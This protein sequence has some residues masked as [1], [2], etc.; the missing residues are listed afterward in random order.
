M[1]I[2]ATEPEYQKGKSVFANVAEFQFVPVASDEESIAAFVQQHTCR[3]V[4]LGVERYVGPLYEAIPKGG[5]IVRFGV[6]TDSIDPLQTKRRGILVA[7]TPGALDRS[8][9]EHTI[10][11]IGALVRH[12]GQGNQ[13]VKNGNWAPLTGDELGD[14]KLAIIGL[15]QIGQQVAQ[16]AHVAFGMETLICKRSIPATTASQM[17]ITEAE[18]QARLGYSMWSDGTEDVVRDADIVSVHL[19]HTPET[20]GFFDADRFAQLKNGALFVNT[21]RG[22]LVVERDLAHALKSGKLAGAALDVYQ[23]EPYHPPEHAD[24]LREYPNVLMTPHVA[25]NTRAANKRMASMVLEN[26]RHWAR[27]EMDAVHV[28]F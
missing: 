4:V 13:D 7:N 15:G 2:P 19:P 22:G 1:I 23:N 10:F 6:G 8:V 25:S 11:L 5:I 26:L 24:D 20:K 3:A 16:I 17:G 14:L 21:S 12:I 27:G 28:A 18:L 9:A